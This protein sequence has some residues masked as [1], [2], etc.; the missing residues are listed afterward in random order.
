MNELGLFAAAIAISNT[1]ER[2]AFLDGECIGRPELRSRVDQLLEAHFQCNPLL[3]Q[4]AQG[5]PTESHRQFVE[6][7]G[8]VIADRY[9]L[10]QQIGEGGMGSVWMAD[11][12]KPVKRRVAVKLIRT[13][14]GQSKTILSRFQ[15]ERQAIALMDHPHIAKLLDAGTTDDEC[16]FF[17][18]ELVKGVPLT[19]YCDAQRLSIQDR[20]QLFMQICSAVQHAHQKGIIH[21]DLKPTNILV[22]SHDDKPVPKVIDFG[23]A[24]A[25]SG[26]QLTENTLFTG[27]GTVMGTP[28]Y[29]APEQAK[30]SAVDVDTRADIYA[31]GVILYELLTG[32]TPLTRETIKQAALDEM[33]KLIREQEAPMPSSRLSSSEGRPSIAANRQT[34]PQKLGRFIK[35]DLDWIV[36]KALSKERDRRYESAN[37]FAKDIERFLQQEPVTAG[38]PSTS[39]WM[40]KF[41]QRNRGQVI[42]ASL[43]LLTLVLGIIGTLWGLVR[44]ANANAE[45]ANRNIDLSYE[46]AKVEARNH[47]LA[48][49]NAALAAEQAKVRA[50]ETQAIA[51]VKR[52]GDVVSEND[53]LKNNPALESL[54][55]ELLREPLAF[56]RELRTQIQA[57][58]DTRPESLERLGDASFQLGRL[59]GEIGDKQDALVAL[60]ESLALYQKL[61]DDSP[62]VAKFQYNV[63]VTLNQI[64]ILLSASGKLAKA[65]SVHESASS[66]YET[67]V[68]SHPAVTEYQ[69]N[70]AASH[71]SIAILLQ[72]RGETAKPLKAYQ[73]AREVYQR[74]ADAHPDVPMY[75][76]NLASSETAIAFLLN[77]TGRFTEAMK[78]HESSLAI[79]EKLALADPTIGKFQT[80]LADSHDN[81]GALLGRTGNWAEAEAKVR[82]ALAIRVK[83]AEDNPALTE[84]RSRAA[85]GHNNLGYLLSQTDQLEKAEVEFR[86]ALAIERRLV[87]DNPTI[88]DFS[89]GLALTQH[90]LASMLSRTGRL[91]E[92]E[93]EFRGALAIRQKLAE[94]NPKV[95]E[96]VSRLAGTRN[97]LGTVLF[98]MGQPAKAEAELQQALAI[99]RKLA[100]DSPEVTEFR[101][102]LAAT[103]HNFGIM[104]QLQGNLPGAESEYRKALEILQAFDNN[105]LTETEI[106]T[107]LVNSLYNLAV[108]L[109]Q[110]DKHAEAEAGFRK[111]LEFAPQH[112]AAKQSLTE[113]LKKAED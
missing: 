74:L 10:L 112:T 85:E 79:Y 59:T 89:N 39:Y 100:E 41:V 109:A 23:L 50:R 99:Y 38:P 15:A 113:L 9:K 45:L 91:I 53:S 2:A 78:A 96:Y 69:S 111:V 106:R 82:Q 107:G 72:R 35:G 97:T 5:I 16:P 40:R 37:G 8:T 61:V 75:Q 83:L 64:G 110:T 73:S 47:E 32:T 42:A 98:Q 93:T 44:E 77:A 43:V 54:R 90:N 66:I 108:V 57:D 34:E 19:E 88:S 103:H 25:T 18:M 65:L 4:T 31:L 20:L 94:D 29:M 71:Q 48:A 51:A 68:G 3:D 55:K 56:F 26:L 104:Q 62:E 24:K 1:V 80:G 12:T 6:A 49:K 11:Q 84:F 13:E 101:S 30:F 102:S 81:L 86:K 17:V 21:R 58:H 70:L 22:E 105:I 92:A 36:M 76:M 14:R 67:L 28:L 87:D 95:I 60:Y 46:Q 7:E 63:A 52:F 27:F 33:L